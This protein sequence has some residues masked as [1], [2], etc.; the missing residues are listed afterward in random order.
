MPYYHWHLTDVERLALPMKPHRMPQAQWFAPF[1]L[2]TVPRKVQKGNEE[3][4]CDDEVEVGA[5]L[6]QI[7][8]SNPTVYLLDWIA[9]PKMMYAHSFATTTYG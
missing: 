9:P 7:Y 6:A 5:R 3:G 1:N 4:T 8:Q 2:P